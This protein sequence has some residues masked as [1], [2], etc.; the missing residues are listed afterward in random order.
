MGTLA[1]GV[2][3]SLSENSPAK[4]N[5]L[6]TVLVRDTWG[7]PGHPPP[8]RGSILS[9]LNCGG[10]GEPPGQGLGP[11]VG[12]GEGAR[13]RARRF[14]V[15]HDGRCVLRQPRPPPPRTLQRGNGMEEQVCLG[16]NNLGPKLQKKVGRRRRS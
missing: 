10:V 11:G 14:G 3:P 5:M 7:G 9:P 16:G 2:F 6:T 15:R 4:N 13:Q 8:L 12:L 1:L